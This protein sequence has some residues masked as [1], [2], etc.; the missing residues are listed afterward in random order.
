MAVVS[1]DYGHMLGG[2][3]TSALG[4][5]SGIRTYG[6]VTVNELMRQGHELINCTPPNGPMTL[7]Q[8]LNYRVNKANESGSVL[9]ICF[10]ENAFDG[11]VHGSEVFVASDAGAKYGNSILDEICK[12]GFENRGVKR[13]NL[14]VTKNTNMVCVLIEPLFCDNPSDVAMSSPLLIGL[15]IAK[16][17]VNIIGGNANPVVKEVVK[18]DSLNDIAPTGANIT[19]L[20]GGGWIE[21]A[22][23]GRSILHQSRSVYLALTS[24]GH[25]NFTANGN[26]KQ[27]V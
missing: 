20:A 22:A 23:D 1:Y 26:T 17:V 8:S 7:M 27:L 24:D 15:A 11:V 2:E 3:D 4:E 21:R 16:G 18:V 12:L 9:H 25:L 14:Y 19:L 13:D 5:Y 6:P 10:H